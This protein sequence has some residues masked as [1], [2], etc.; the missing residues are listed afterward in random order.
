MC[1]CVYI[2]THYVCVQYT[3]THTHTHKQYMYIH[4]Y[5]NRWTHQLVLEEEGFQDAHHVA[6]VRADL[7]EYILVRNTFFHMSA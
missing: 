5:V 7:R 6:D 4:T 3:H 2:Y 1:V